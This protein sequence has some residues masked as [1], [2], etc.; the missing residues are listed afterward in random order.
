MASEGYIRWTEPVKN[1]SVSTKARTVESVFHC[2]L[3]QE[4]YPVKNNS[5]STEAWM[6]EPVLYPVIE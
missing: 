2:V 4:K 5:V 1:Y 3:E 6:A